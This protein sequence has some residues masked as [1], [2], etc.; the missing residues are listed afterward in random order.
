MKSKQQLERNIRKHKEA[1]LVVNTHSRKGQLL[2]EKTKT[3][4]ISHGFT[5]TKTFAI[6]HPHFI[7]STIKKA[8]STNPEFIVIGSG[9]GTIASVVD[10]LAY[11]D[12]VLGYLPLGTTN[13]F[14]RSLEVPQKLEDAIDVIV[15]GKV[16]DVDLGTVNGDYFGNMASMGVSVMVANRTT[17]KLKRILGRLAYGI[18]STGAIFSHKPFKVTVHKNDLTYTFHTHQFNVLNGSV[19]SGKPIAAN[20]SIDNHMLTAYSLGGTSRFSAIKATVEHLLTT[21]ELM[22]NKNFIT[23]QSIVIT[24]QP[25]QSL[26]IDGEVKKGPKNGT[27]TFKVAPEALKVLVPQHFNDD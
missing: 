22:E 7:N 16:A 27:Y 6:N 2:Y 15:H 18:Y 21:Q 3:L 19:H 17:R 26:D 13:N 5:L 10:H 23:G 4:L 25:T 20:A 24:T 12:T 8:L 9:D 14:G 11:T 1:V